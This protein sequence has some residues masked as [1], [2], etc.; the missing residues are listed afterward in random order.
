MSLDHE[1]EMT[2][3]VWRMCFLINALEKVREGDLQKKDFKINTSEAGM[4]MKTNKSRTK[5]LEKVGHLCL[6]FGHLRRTDTNFAENNAFVTR[7]CRFN[8]V[9]HGF[10]HA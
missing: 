1:A 3:E 8:L 5:C 7:I 4:C 10:F 2:P 9:F 6:R